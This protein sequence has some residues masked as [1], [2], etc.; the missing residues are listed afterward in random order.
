MNKERYTDRMDRMVAAIDAG[1]RAASGTLAIAQVVDSAGFYIEA[2]DK[3]V[4]PVNDE[5]HATQAQMLRD[6]AMLRKSASLLFQVE[7]DECT[8]RARALHVIADR[9]DPAGAA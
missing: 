8:R 6:A 2:I 7:T 5:A 4:A 3:H 9:L 1:D